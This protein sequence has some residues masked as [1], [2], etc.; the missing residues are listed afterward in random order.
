MKHITA[1][2]DQQTNLLELTFDELAVLEPFLN[3]IGVRVRTTMY[4]GSV[5]VIQ[6]D[7]PY[8]DWISSEDRVYADKEMSPD[9]L[10]CYKY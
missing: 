9:R 10:R 6:A 4:S 3:R 8:K 2:Y 5:N 7:N 1:E